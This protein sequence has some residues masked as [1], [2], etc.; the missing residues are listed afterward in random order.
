MDR[1]MLVIA[2][3]AVLGITV[4]VPIVS[5]DSSAMTEMKGR[6]SIAYISSAETTVPANYTISTNTLYMLHGS[7]NQIAMEEYLRDPQNS[8]PVE[9]DD[10]DLVMK[11]EQGTPIDIYVISRNN[12]AEST[13][14]GNNT[15][16][17]TPR[18]APYVID[19]DAE[20][21]DVVKIKIVEAGGN[22][23]DYIN[24]ISFVKD[25]PNPSSSNYS[26]GG[27]YTTEMDDDEKLY[28]TVVWM[29]DNDIYV[30]VEYTISVSAPNGSATLFAAACIVISALAIIILVVATMKPKWAK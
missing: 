5:D 9:D 3:I 29:R 24:V 12:Y 23:S 7:E 30:D 21:G 19:V 13:W 14:L 15:I 6:T 22:F 8:A 26:V 2:L 11:S 25:G 28:M 16:Q 4:L 10:R 1:K 17:L 27:I 20:A 18:L